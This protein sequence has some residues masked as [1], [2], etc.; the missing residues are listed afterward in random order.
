[1]LTVEPY[2]FKNRSPESGQ[3]WELIASNLNAVHAPRFRVSQTSVRDRAR[4][5]LKNYKIKIRE[6][7]KMSGIVVPEVSELVAL[8]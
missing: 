2:K 7:E 1:M 3:A 5:L 4:S 8:E 6:E